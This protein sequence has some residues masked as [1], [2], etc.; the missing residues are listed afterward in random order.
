[1]GLIGGLALLAATPAAAQDVVGYGTLP[2]GS[3]ANAMM[4]AIV[5]VV[6]TKE[7]L[8]GVVQPHAGSTQFLP[9]LN[10][11]EL[12]FANTNALDAHFARQGIEVFS[13]PNPKLRMVTVIY[14]LRQQLLVRKDSGIKSL[15]ELKGKRVVGGYQAQRSVQ[16]LLEGLLAGAGLS[17]SEV[18]MVP[19]PNVVRGLEEFERGRADASLGAMEMPKVREVAAQTSIAFLSSVPTP[20]ALAAMQK[21]APPAYFDEV[22]PSA[23]QPGM[24]RP[25]VVQ[26]YDYVLLTRSDLPDEV[27]YKVVKAMHDNKGELEAA[28][29]GF[30]EFEPG[31]MAKPG[32]VDYHPGAIRFYSEKGLW[33]PKG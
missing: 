29:P 4:N 15:A 20:A 22:K 6:S 17:M 21:I 31:K 26:A 2:P 24:E 18:Q 19:I 16:V 11:G 13:S 1:M 30:R 5:K 10:R 23:A 9:L 33:P 3:M 14:P 12:D 25:T 7:N 8:P 28:V 27:V 32:T